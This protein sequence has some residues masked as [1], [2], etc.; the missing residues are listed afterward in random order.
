MRAVAAT[1]SGKFLFFGQLTG[2]IVA[3]EGEFASLK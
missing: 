1:E 2:K 3:V